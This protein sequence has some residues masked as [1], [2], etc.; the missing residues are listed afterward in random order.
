MVIL[1]NKGHHVWSTLKSGKESKLES[2]GLNGDGDWIKAA[3]ELTSSDEFQTNCLNVTY[4]GRGRHYE[5]SDDD[6]NDGYDHYYE[7]LGR[8][9]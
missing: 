4:R 6:D 5:D 8:Y 2:M 3:Q 7:K 9:Y 1:F